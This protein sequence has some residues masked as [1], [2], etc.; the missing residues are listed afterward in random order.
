MNV[1]GDGIRRASA[2]DC[3]L[4]NRVVEAAPAMSD[5]EDNAALFR[6]ER[7]RQQFSLLHDIG[8]GTGDVRRTRIGVGQDIAG[9]QQVENLR[10]E[11]RS[12][13]AA[14][15]ARHPPYGT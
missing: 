5:I 2:R 10:H 14:D 12:L 11:L 4:R 1:G 9:P 13:D 15:M 7:G 8:E 3:H 6:R